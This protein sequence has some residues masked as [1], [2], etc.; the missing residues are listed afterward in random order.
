[1][2]LP[3]KQGAFSLPPTHPPTHQPT[4]PGAVLSHGNLIANAAGTRA[5]LDGYTAGDRHISYLPLAHIYERNNLTVRGRDFVVLPCAS[6]SC[7]RCL[8][9]AWGKGVAAGRLSS[10]G[11]GPLFFVD[12]LPSGFLPGDV[13][14][15]RHISYLP[16]AHIYERNNLRVGAVVLSW[17]FDCV[18]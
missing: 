14:V 18:R 7:G 2:E 3:A 6:W 5:L 8:P 15:D 12:R 16:L 9:R 11:R 13:R 17:G 1:M 4:H 10:P